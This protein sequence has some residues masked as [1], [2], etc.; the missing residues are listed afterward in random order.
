MTPCPEAFAKT[1][2]HPHDGRGLNLTRVIL[3]WAGR[4]YAGVARQTSGRSSG[5]Q[6]RLDEAGRT[7]AGGGP[8]NPPVLLAPRA[9]GSLQ[10]IHKRPGSPS[11]PQT[12][13]LCRTYF[14][15][16]RAIAR[17]ATLPLV[18]CAPPPVPQ[19][20]SSGSRR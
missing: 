8:K 11:A 10:S 19:A 15:Q 20:R 16:A 7:G 12:G 18:I 5:K 9:C 14:T 13:G 4:R 17:T 6:C 2:E 1:A 3:A